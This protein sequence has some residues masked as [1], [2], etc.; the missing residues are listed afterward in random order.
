[1]KKLFI[2]LSFI[3][4]N[5]SAQD[6]IVKKD[7]ST[8]L[9]KVLEI[10]KEDIKYKKFSNQKGPTYTINKS[11]IMSINYENGEKD[12]FSSDSSTKKS[13]ESN[14][15]PQLL[16]PAVG[17]NNTELIAL[18]NQDNHYTQEKKSKKTKHQILIYHVGRESVLKNTDLEVSFIT[19]GDVFWYFHDL[20]IKFTNLTD[21][22]I[23]ID[24]GNSF[25]V[26]KVK[27]MGPNSK[28]N[29]IDFYGWCEHTFIKND[30]W[31]TYYDNTITQS[32][33]G[34]GTG[35]GLNM[36][37]VA[38][39]L[40]VGGPIGTLASGVTVS[41]SEMQSTTTVT[42]QERI[43]PIPPHSSSIIS[44]SFAAPQNINL[45]VG[46]E[47]E[48]TEEDTPFKK[49]FFFTY[50]KDPNFESYGTIKADVFLSKQIGI[51]EK[52]EKQAEKLLSN[53]N[54]NTLWGMF[55]LLNKWQSKT[56]R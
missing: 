22:T 45:T 25:C 8:I 12:D 43:I 3:T 28:M 11:E 37:A 32:T 6:V 16:N 44:D 47:I 10:N 55:Q 46:E 18:Y 1:M 29:F 2:L 51:Q 39:A 56:I 13:N 50:S 49:N 14:N 53:Q 40:G 9:S 52:D 36:G 30:M 38:G 26:Y 48:Y 31:R 5:V 4:L 15:T 34:S 35:V 7:G 27:E 19:P 24:K 20:K 42:Q 17:E 23:Y 21:K 41:R 54:S 33:Y